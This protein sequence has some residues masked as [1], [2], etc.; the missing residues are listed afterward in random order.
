MG[1][2]PT[3]KFVSTHPS[4]FSPDNQGQI[5]FVDKKYFADKKYIR[6][7]NDVWIGANVT[8][9]D[10]VHIG[11]GAIIAAGV[12]VT[13]NVD[14][15]S[16]VGGV[17]AKTIKY[18]FLKDEIDCLLKNEWWNKDIRWIKEHHELFLDIKKYIKYINNNNIL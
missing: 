11:N 14:A 10:G 12:V 15:F 2:H 4:F 1:F 9:L 8:I 17:P 6:I 3:N 13:K 16:I 7:D 18:R 5:S